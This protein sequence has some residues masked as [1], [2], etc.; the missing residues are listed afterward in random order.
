LIK[1]SAKRD[2]AAGVNA[3]LK[4]RENQRFE[5]AAVTLAGAGSSPQKDEAKAE[6]LMVAELSSCM[7]TPHG[8]N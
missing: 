8:G 6:E 4:L 7:S 3:S 5:F 2:E 1:T